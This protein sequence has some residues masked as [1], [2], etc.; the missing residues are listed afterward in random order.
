MN[1][2]DVHCHLTHK[3]FKGKVEEIIRRAEAVGLKAIVVSGVNPPTNR[4]VLALSK[5]YPVIK[6]SIGIYPIDALGIQPEG[7]GL[8]H[9][10]GKINLESEFK[11]IEENLDAISC[12]GEVGADFYWATKEET[13]DEQAAIFRKVIQFAIKV[14][15]PIV[16]HSRK[17]E[18]E[19]L[20]ILEEEIKHKEIP[21]VQ[22]CFSGRKSLMTRAIDLGH[23]FSIPPNILVASNF[24][25]LVKKAPLMQLLTETDAPW[26]S[27]EKGVPNEP[28]NVLLTV[29][30]IAEVKGVSVE[31]VADQIWDNYKRVFVNV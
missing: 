5:K 17:A 18:E 29:K 23:Y 25:T 22:H 15:K 6:A 16:I 27:P 1:L 30:K 11:F 8:S 26:L 4:E 19:C 24:Q 7:I 28:K 20:D 14:G 3:L 13:F 2:V 21:V 12:I 9:H 31:E 10:K